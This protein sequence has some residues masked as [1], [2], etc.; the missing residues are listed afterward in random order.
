[1][2]FES[3]FIYV[4]LDEQAGGLIVAWDFM[5]E[6]SPDRDRVYNLFQSDQKIPEKM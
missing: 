6:H 4:R 2:Q 1:M 5:Q 3:T